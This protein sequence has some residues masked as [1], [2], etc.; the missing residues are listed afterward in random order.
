MKNTLKLGIISL[1]F[2][3]IFGCNSNDEELNESES[4]IGT[5][6]FVET[7]QS[8]GGIGTWNPVENGYKYTFLEN[9][10]F[11]SNRFDECINGT[12]LIESNELTLIFGCNG[13]TAG[14]EAP[15]GTFIEEINFESGYLFINPTYIFCV[16]GCD[17]KFKKIN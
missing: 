15:E 1:L 9:G 7:Y 4:I 3:S 5:W 6:Q 14:I 10:N 11:S 2:V 8:T 12:Y 17:N 16:E 13:F